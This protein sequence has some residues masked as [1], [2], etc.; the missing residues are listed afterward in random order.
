MNSNEFVSWLKG[1][2][3]GCGPELTQEQVEHIKMMLANVFR[4][5]CPQQINPTLPYSPPWTIGDEPYNPHKIWYTTSTGTNPSVS[6]N[7]S[8]Y[9]NT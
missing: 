6:E 4:V 9:N 7:P 2:I 3:D 1:Y 8:D 5:D